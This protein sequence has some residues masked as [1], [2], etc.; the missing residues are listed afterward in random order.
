VVYAERW[1]SFVRLLAPN[2]VN[3]PIASFPDNRERRG[4]DEV[5]RFNEA[6][7]EAWAGDFSATP[8]TVRVYGDAV[9]SRVLFTGHAST[10][11]VEISGRV[12][13][14]HFFQDGLITRWED[15]TDRAEALKAAG[16]EG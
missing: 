7:F 12:F 9:V 4:R 8:D 16:V 5:R 13:V 3:R 1:D 14:V 15:F 10:S 6:F 2:V 11:G